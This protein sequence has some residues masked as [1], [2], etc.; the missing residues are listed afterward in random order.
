MEKT[1]AQG[2]GSRQTVSKWELD[3]AYPEMN[4]LLGLCSLFSCSL[5]QL[6][7]EDFCVSDAACSDIRMDGD[8]RVFSQ[9]A[10]RDL[11]IG[12]RDPMAALFR[13]IPG[14]CKVLMTHM[15]VNGLQARTDDGAIGC[16]EREYDRE[17]AYC[18]DVHIAL[19]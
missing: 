13:L 11:V 19:A 6:V 8:A 10:Q 14:A 16:Y 2:G 7:R 4:K 12:I 15:Q 17:G 1:N 18:M 3:A 5:D 9:P